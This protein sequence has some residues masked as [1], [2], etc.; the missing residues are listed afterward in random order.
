[1]TVLATRSRTPVFRAI[2]LLLL[3]AAVVGCGANGPSGT[4]SG[5]TPTPL[6]V[7]RV[8]LRSV[9]SPT[10]STK[11]VISGTASFNGV[12]GK[13]QGTYQGSGDEAAQ[14]LTLIFGGVSQTSEVV[15]KTDAAWEKN[16]VG[17]WLARTVGEGGPGLTMIGWLQTLNSVANLGP[18]SVAGQDLIH[19]RPA[20]EQPMPP[21]AIGFETNELTD[22]VISVD[23]YAAADGS[24][25]ALGIRASWTMNVNGAPTPVELS[26]DYA[27][28]D[29]GSPV[30]ITAPADVWS[31][32]TNDGFG[33]Q[34]AMPT[35]W[36]VV[37]AGNGDAYAGDGVNKVFV[38]RNPNAA[39]LTLD[40]FRSGITAS[41]QR[42]F[43]APKS[44][45]KSTLGGVPANLLRYEFAGQG[46][47]LQ[48][49]LDRIA[50]HG[51]AGWEV[52][53]VTASSALEADQALYESF[54]ASFVF[55]R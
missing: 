28:E 25:A 35:G 22:P 45:T 51:P 27:L 18:A 11:G 9:T 52:S 23:L 39:G 50:M 43:G 17:P 19:L 32:N 40:E 47:T 15:T 29:V 10:F 24:P 5:P 54:V 46:G 33:Y 12:A 31:L 4:P 37:S 26:L 7:G 48:V 2:A 49:L 44:V 3:A 41:Y 34:M 53:L 30:T 1:M 36:S 20:A 21:E 42:Q 6:D 13:A 8:F 38:G 55:T 16:G 14:S